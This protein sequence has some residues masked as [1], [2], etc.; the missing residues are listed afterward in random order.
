MGQIFFIS[1]RVELN[2]CSCK[3]ILFLF[4]LKRKTSGRVKPFCI[5]KGKKTE[6]K[7]IFF[8]RL[9]EKGKVETWTCLLNSD[10]KTNLIIFLI[11]EWQRCYWHSFLC[12]WWARPRQS[13]VVGFMTAHQTC[14]ITKTLANASAK[15]WTAFLRQ[16]PAP[17]QRC[18]TRMCVGVQ[19]VTGHVQLRLCWTRANASA[20]AESW[21]VPIPNDP[22]GWT[23]FVRTGARESPADPSTPSTWTTAAASALPFWPAPQGRSSTS[24]HA[25][26]TPSVEASAARKDLPSTPTN[27][28]ASAGLRPGTAQRE[29]HSTRTHVHVSPAL[30]ARTRQRYRISIANVMLRTV[31]ISV[32]RKGWR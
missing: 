2:I 24:T 28:S 4:C 8:E 18:G 20:S 31:I 19:G 15:V 16:P 3:K 12:C 25:P 17:L 11:L 23:V 22:T 27:V 29:N 21:T 1:T 9:F 10:A 32:V 14:F 13:F 30:H 7:G 6:N 5:K 26:V